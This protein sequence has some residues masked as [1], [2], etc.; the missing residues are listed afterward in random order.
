MKGGVF[1]TERAFMYLG[2]L[3]FNSARA[4]YVLS[5]PSKRRNVNT[6]YMKIHTLHDKVFLFLKGIFK[7]NILQLDL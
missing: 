3:S 2:L 5:N 4:A 7:C 6:K 1:E